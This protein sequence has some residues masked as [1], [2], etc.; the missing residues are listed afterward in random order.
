M[1][2]G[3]VK[4]PRGLTGRRRERIT[5]A[6]EAAYDQCRTRFDRNVGFD[7]QTF[8]QMVFKSCWFHLDQYLAGDSGV[9]VLRDYNSFELEVE[10]TVLHPYKLGQR[11]GE[12]YDRYPSN[13]EAFAFMAAENIEQITLFPSKSPRRLVLAHAGNPIDGLRAVYIA[14]PV[15]D[16]DGDF[17][18]AWV[19][20]ID[21]LGGES[22]VDRPEPVDIPPP[23]LG[24]VEPTP[25]RRRADSSEDA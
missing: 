14:A 17:G 9:R 18:W 7:N 11:D 21:E 25:E 16:G 5:R 4:L 1:A 6:L 12:I 20:R 10:G 2:D 13:E 19:V 22:G 8:G 3:R 23:Q 24:T 15:M